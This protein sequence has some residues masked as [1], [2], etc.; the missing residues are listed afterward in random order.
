MTAEIQTIC[1][2][3]DDQ[4][5]TA[6]LEG[7]L[8]AAGYDVR[9]FASA[10]RFLERM[11]A[12]PSDSIILADVYMPGLDGI[13]LMERLGGVSSR[14]P[15]VIMT[16][17]ASVRMAIDALRAGAADFVE[18]PFTRFELLGA[19]D[20]A[21]CRNGAANAGPSIPAGLTEHYGSLSSREVEVF[22]LMV[23]GETSKVIARRLGI[24]P[25]TVEVHRSHVLHK[26]DSRN[27]ADLIHKASRLGIH[28]DS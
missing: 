1:V 16:G 25:R 6:S 2:I 3:D 23:A 20:R 26:M 24:S 27:L 9:A 7:L 17:H 5:V 18:K 28:P 21:Q 8:R 14:F 19:L 10:D 11:D 4:A 22:K 15:V 13:Q 12:I